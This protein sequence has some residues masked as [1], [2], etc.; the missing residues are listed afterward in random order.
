M[1]LVILCSKHL[2]PLWLVLAS[3]QGLIVAE[4]KDQSMAR[5]SV[6][7]GKLPC[8]LRGAR[9]LDALLKGLVSRLSELHHRHTPSLVVEF[10]TLGF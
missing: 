8:L 5:P 6:C 3:R 1:P 9:P 4:T 7:P 2:I 10:L